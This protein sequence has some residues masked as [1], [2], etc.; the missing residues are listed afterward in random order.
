[1]VN[2]SVDISDTEIQLYA[3]DFNLSI[4]CLPEN[5]GL[6]YEWE[7]NYAKFP[8][9]AHGINTS[10]LIIFNIRPEDSGEYRCKLSNS[11]GTILSKFVAI[12]VKGK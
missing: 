3:S 8:E 1:M 11:T 12:T 6:N 10:Q 7:R 4:K 5:T 9:N 2:I